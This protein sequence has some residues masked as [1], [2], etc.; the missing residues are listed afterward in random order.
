MNKFYSQMFKD[1]QYGV[2]NRFAPESFYVKYKN[3]D[4]TSF[5]DDKNLCGQMYFNGRY[6][7]IEDCIKRGIRSYSNFSA[8]VSKLK[9]CVVLDGKSY[10]HNTSY[11]RV[12]RFG[13][14]DLK[15]KEYKWLKSEC[16]NAYTETVTL[17]GNYKLD[18]VDKE[19]LYNKRT[20][21]GIMYL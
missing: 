12:E 20:I 5:I 6:K 11:I 7:E 2:R 10:L 14:M 16:D 9:L 19:L 21:T 15:L 1:I 3:K 13:D 17:A 4:I 18:K 8:K